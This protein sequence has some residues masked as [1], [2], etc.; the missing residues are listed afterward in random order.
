MQHFDPSFVLDIDINGC[1]RA[2]VAA[3]VDMAG[4]LGLK[5]IAEGVASYRKLEVLRQLGCRY[6]QGN[7]FS[8]PVPAGKF[9]PLL[10]KLP[11]TGC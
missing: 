7:F 8:P 5:V 6:F 9:A 11:Q 4:G 2:I 3:L 10:R 1:S